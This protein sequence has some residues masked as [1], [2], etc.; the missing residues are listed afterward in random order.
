MCD[1]IKKKLT[2]TSKHFGPLW[3]YMVSELDE[4]YDFPK[5]GNFLDI[6]CG[7]G[8]L[9]S[10][11]E[12]KFNYSNVIGISPEREVIE[13]ID[14]YY[15][16]ISFFPYSVEKM[17]GYDEYF[18]F[19]FSRGSYRF[20]ENKLEGFKNTY[21][22][23]KKG[24]SALIGGGFGNKVTKSMVKQARINIAEELTKDDG[25]EGSVP[26]PTRDELADILISAGIKD[27]A[28]T[29]EDFSGMWIYIKK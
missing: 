13:C 4:I 12:K 29:P 9:T 2:V 14:N 23:M 17:K 27:F 10:L 20:W 5:N 25:R 3:E 15:E 6:G 26:Y 28:F 16:K 19:I 7:Y 22:M 24:S 11:F 1:Y 8:V 18:D 21:N